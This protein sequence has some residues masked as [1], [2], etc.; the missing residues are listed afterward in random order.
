MSGV[1]SASAGTGAAAHATALG[2]A[3]SFGLSSLAG[4]VS[5]PPLPRLSMAAT[6]AA[7]AGDRAGLGALAAGVGARSRMWDPALCRGPCQMVKCCWIEAIAADSRYRITHKN[8]HKDSTQMSDDTWHVRQGA[9]VDN[10]D[11]L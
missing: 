3:S 6:A 11:Y 10:R 7:T 9:E 4:T 2:A 5:S 8:V 1:L